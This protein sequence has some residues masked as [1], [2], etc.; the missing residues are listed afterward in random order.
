MAFAVLI[1][2]L[3]HPVPLATCHT[4]PTI[5]LNSTLSSFS[6]RSSIALSLSSLSKSRRSS[7]IRR[8]LRIFIEFL[9]LFVFSI[10]VTFRGLRFAPIE[11]SHTWF[12]DL[13]RNLSCSRFLFTLLNWCFF[14]LGVK[15]SWGFQCR[16][17]RDNWLFVQLMP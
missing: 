11:L 3:F 7:I 1:K 5:H 2:F 15:K 16:E 13:L 6:H 12:L 10:S 14:P 17:S 9:S 8:F 4:G